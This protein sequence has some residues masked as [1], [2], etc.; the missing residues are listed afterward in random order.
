M[1]D[2]S[3]FVRGS[4]NIFR[5]FG[6]PDADLE[7]LRAILAAKIVGVLEDRGLSVRKAAEITGVDAGDFSRIRR[8]NFGRFTIDRLMMILARL[9]QEV[10]VDVRV[11]SK[12]RR[13]VRAAAG[14]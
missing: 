8:A 9:D 7:Q 14:R 11:R 6:R 3:E 5:D 2:D 10:D 1:S 12:D 13:P 4:G